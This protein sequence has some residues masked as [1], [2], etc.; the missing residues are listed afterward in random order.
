MA[1]FC[2]ERSL[3]HWSMIS[4]IA[5][6]DLAMELH[7]EPHS[8]QSEGCLIGSLPCLR[9]I[10]AIC[11]LGTIRGGAPFSKARLFRGK[12]SPSKSDRSIDQSPALAGPL[13]AVARL[14][15]LRILRI[16]PTYWRRRLVPSHATHTC[17]NN[18]FASSN[19]HPPH[20]RAYDREHGC[21]NSSMV[22]E[23]LGAYDCSTSFAWRALSTCLRVKL[24]L[25]ESRS[26]ELKH[27]FR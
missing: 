20:A 3:K 17:R 13:V 27:R 14:R 5:V 18:S 26:R 4:T 16:L 22:F 9:R 1:E 23:W 8:S 25:S 19:P 7:H 11:Q 2:A 6:N 24:H 15:I 12:P 21:V 10:L